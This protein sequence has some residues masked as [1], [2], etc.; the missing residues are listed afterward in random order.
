MTAERDVCELIEGDRKSPRPSAAKQ[1]CNQHPAQGHNCDYG[2][3]QEQQ[4]TQSDAPR[5]A[6]RPQD[7]GYHAI[8]PTATKVAAALS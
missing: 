5:P 7:V 4:Q 2:A 1:K 8:A 6:D 3:Q